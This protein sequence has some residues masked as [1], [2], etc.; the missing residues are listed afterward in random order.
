MQKY[1]DEYGEYIKNNGKKLMRPKKDINERKFNYT[2]NDK[3]LNISEYSEDIGKRKS[4]LIN[5][6][7]CEKN[8]SIKNVGL[9]S[10]A[11]KVIM[12]LND[13]QKKFI[14]RWLNTCIIMYNKTIKYLKVNKKIGYNKLRKNL[15]CTKNHYK[16]MSKP[17]LTSNNNKEIPSHILDEAIKE[18]HINHKNAELKN[19]VC[20]Y[21][22]FNDKKKTM[23]IE[24]CNFN[25]GSILMKSL[26]DAK[27]IYKNR[28]EI[29]VFDPCTIER[30]S[31]LQKCNSNYYLFA[32]CYGNY[33]EWKETKIIDNKNN[34]GLIEDKKK[35]TKIYYEFE[36]KNNTIRNHTFIGDLGK[37]KFLTGYCPSLNKFTKI[38][39]GTAEYIWKDV[40]RAEKNTKIY[41]KLK[42]GEWLF[43]MRKNETMRETKKRKLKKL[44]KNAAKY[45]KKSENKITEL[46]WQTI[47]YLT[48]NYENIIIGDIK[49]RS[50]SQMNISKRLKRILL[51]LKFFKFKK[52][53][54]GK[55]KER[56]NGFKL[57]SEFRSS[58]RCSKCSTINENL[59]D[60][61]VYICINKRCK[62][63]E[64]R[65]AN[66]SIN[67]YMHYM[68]K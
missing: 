54:E 24:L 11:K 2:I 23:H 62:Y 28:N 18:A 13:K 6:N 57:V 31:I 32:V 56:G 43:K 12:Q 14:D 37:R 50:L 33:G 46:H 63:K 41:K 15:E 59:K 1:A 55:C 22:K 25:K 26:K 51:K 67:L 27:F 35:D 42:S 64:D 47:N 61:E 5:K 49:M 3:I 17:K 65:D 9:S 36:R 39:E 66:A 60:S 45:K 7:I 19:G 30:T 4:N 52:R 40:E 16:K 21:K 48:K 38:G 34:I 58:K 29:T 53:L 10:K 44:R 68:A 8:I 20:S